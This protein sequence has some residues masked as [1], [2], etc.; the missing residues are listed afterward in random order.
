MTTLHVE[1]C[2]VWL[3]AVKPETITE[4]WTVNGENIP[5]SSLWNHIIHGGSVA[6]PDIA[7]ATIYRTEEQQNWVITTRTLDRDEVL[8]DQFVDKDGNTIYIVQR[9]E[10]GRIRPLA[11]GTTIVR[12][13]TQPTEAVLMKLMSL[14][15]HAGLTPIAL[16]ESKLFAAPAPSRILSRF[17]PTWHSNAHTMTRAGILMKRPGGLELPVNIPNTAIWTEKEND[18][19][20][21]ISS[22]FSEPLPGT[23]LVGDT[24]LKGVCR[25]PLRI[26]KNIESEGH[27][28]DA[29]FGQTVPDNPT[30]TFYPVRHLPREQA[31]LNLQAVL[32]GAEHPENVIRDDNVR[33][34]NLNIKDMLT[35][36]QRR[37]VKAGVPVS[38]LIGELN[39]WK[40]AT[41][42]KCAG[43]RAT[44]F[45]SALVDLNTIWLLPESYRELRLANGGKTPEFVVVHRDPALPNASSMVTYRLAG[46]AKWTSSSRGRGIVLNPKE[47]NWKLAGGDFDGDSAL[48]FAQ[49]Y[50]PL[51][52]RVP[53]TKDLKRNTKRPVTETTLVTEIMANFDGFASQ[54]GPTIAAA[55]RLAEIDRL[56]PELRNTTSIV[57]QGAVSAQKHVMDTASGYA[58]YKEIKD[59]VP[60]DTYL[61]DLL[62]NIGNAPEIATA[63]NPSKADL[64]KN[65]V[66][67][68]LEVDTDTLSRIQ[69]P[70]IERI[71]ILNELYESVDWL[72][73]SRSK[74][75][76]PDRLRNAAKQ[77][78]LDVEGIDAAEHTAWVQ[79][80]TADYRHVMRAIHDTPEEDEDDVDL[81]EQR[82]LLKTLRNELL[83]AL[84]NKD[85]H[86][87]ALLAYGPHRI[88]AE[89]VD[90]DYFEALSQTPSQ[91]ELPIVGE[92]EDGTYHWSDLHIVPSELKRDPALQAIAP[93]TEVYIAVMRKTAKTTRV[94]ATF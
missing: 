14:L 53:V 59:Q 73:E 35:N 83:Q 30:G 23:L 82:E 86:P 3:K 18:G 75:P 76:L 29:Q 70:L 13:E 34:E 40:W 80:W 61:L 24:F 47:P 31:A 93:D 4:A 42:L 71:L 78:L 49:P 65:L 57:A 64:W 60:K 91:I 90:A 8:S 79:G 22:Q 67:L 62:R 68:A 84:L 58:M 45:G 15:K 41:Q 25:P 87:Y 33:L 85:V 26:E 43:T 36:E 2:K 92:I 27:C 5:S 48:V 20:I 16:V 32:F 89:L 7:H 17:S 52:D 77:A 44:V 6:G 38:L 1:F 50:F 37:K 66:E 46:C 9:T 81:D 12:L 39:P 63:K 74:T 51:A 88:A 55:Q 54:L 94:I 21:L 11:R 56:T 72:R 28:T 19:T 10:N 69:K